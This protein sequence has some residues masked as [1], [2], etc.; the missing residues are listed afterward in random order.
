MPSKTVYL[1]FV[2]ID[3]YEPDKNFGSQSYADAERWG[4]GWYS[5]ILMAATLPNDLPSSYEVSNAMFKL[6]AIDTGSGSGQIK[7]LWRGMDKW[8]STWNWMNKDQ[9]EAW[10]DGD[11]FN[12]NVDLGALFWY[13]DFGG[14]GTLTYY[15][16]SDFED[17]I[18]NAGPG[19]WIQVAIYTTTIGSYLSIN[20]A[21]V[22]FDYT[23][24]G[25]PVITGF[26]PGSSNYGQSTPIDIN[27]LCF[28]AAAF[29]SAQLVVNGVPT[30]DLSGSYQNPTLVEGTVSSS[31]P[32]GE[33]TVRVNLSGKYADSAAKFVVNSVGPVVTSVEGDTG[34]GF[35]K[36][37]K[38]WVYLNGSNLTAP[39][40]SITLLGQ[41][42]QGDFALTSVQ[43]VVAGS[44]I[45]GWLEGP[46]PPGLYKAKAEVTGGTAYSPVFTVS[47]GPAWS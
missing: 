34:A 31:V 43:T 15:G 7:L 8:K 11:D 27:G 13:G 35:S 14:P 12:I 9:P 30:H 4:T 36:H 32:V 40:T 25:T 41:E 22:E 10:K 39:L 19:G 46:I 42:G 37:A 44:K 18:E 20:G 2:Q 45:K 5:V 21:R 16:N 33:Y 28:D 26:S 6:D 1:Q 29:V 38:R 17:Y 24:T 3:Q 47:L 23:P